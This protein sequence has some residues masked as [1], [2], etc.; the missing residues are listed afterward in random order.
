MLTE[1]QKL[2]RYLEQKNR[3]IRRGIE[4]HFT[5][6]SWIE[7]WGND[8]EKRGQYKDN[9]VMAR[10]GDIGAYHP[11]NVRKATVSENS[12]ERNSR[13]M[14]KV[15]TKDGEFESIESAARFYKVTPTAITRAVRYKAS[16]K[17]GKVIIQK[18][19]YHR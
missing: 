9:L 14:C 7:W 10:T 5:Y 6:E 8:I 11:D 1:K 19:I 3:S 2:Y 16:K 12:L 17:Y 4:W 13:Y 15:T 18:E